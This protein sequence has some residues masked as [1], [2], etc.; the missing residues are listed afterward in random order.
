MYAMHFCYG[1][2]ALVTPILTKP[3]LSVEINSTMNTTMLDISELELGNDEIWTI[4][5]LYPIIF[6]FM[7]IP[8]PF[9]LHYFIMERK[10]EKIQDKTSDKVALEEE[11]QMLTRR[12]TVL[13]MMFAFMFYFAMAGIEHG[14][15][16][17]TAV[18]CVNSSL[19]MTKNNAADVLAILYLTFAGDQL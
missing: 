19:K 4:K 14:F 15:R 2:G 1:I 7:I 5:T 18:F 8:T 9:F 12:M 16:S 10:S 13:L 11:G 3:F 6:I 17:F